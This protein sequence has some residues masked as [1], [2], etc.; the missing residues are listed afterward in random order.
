MDDK[1]S[2]F[3]INHRHEKIV[4]VISKQ[5]QL[6]QVL[7]YFVS[8]S[9]LIWIVCVEWIGLR[10][11]T[12]EQLDVFKLIYEL[13]WTY[14]NFFSRLE[15]KLKNSSFLEGFWRLLDNLPTAPA[16]LHPSSC[17]HVSLLKLARRK[18]WKIFLF[19][20]F[21]QHNTKLFRNF[22]RFDF[23]SLI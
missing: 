23:A 19:C 2:I 16:E 13:W 10:R 12:L 15:K 18:I 4:I 9:W 8:R 21:C 14:Y 3:T 6:L 5:N 22:F 1:S 17:F 11:W 7:K 20:S